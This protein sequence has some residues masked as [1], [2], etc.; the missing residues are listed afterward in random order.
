[1]AGGDQR[2]IRFQDQLL[3]DRQ[4]KRV[5]CIPT[6]WG[7]QFQH[8]ALS[9]DCYK[10]G[11]LYPL[12]KKIHRYTRSLCCKNLIFDALFCNFVVFEQ[13]SADKPSAGFERP[14]AAKYKARCGAVLLEI[15]IWTTTIPS[16]C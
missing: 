11:I 7:C 5:P 9:S 2:F 12:Y 10:M 4:T 1:Q 13:K 8:S 16:A 3:V 14:F 6:Q 15:R